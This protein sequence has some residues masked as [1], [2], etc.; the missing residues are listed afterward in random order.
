PPA[1]VGDMIVVGSA[2]ADNRR[3][4]ATSGEVRG[5]DAPTGQLKWTWDPVPQDPSDP[6]YASWQGAEAHRSGAA[7]TW[8]VIAADP[9]R[10]LVFLP[11]SSPSVDY[12]GGDRIGDN[13]HANSI[14]ALRASTGAL[15]W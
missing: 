10:D 4:D 3:T 6:A 12:W 2:V 13:L 7:N 5:Y 8:S 11:T 9:A 15:V 14:V 1:V